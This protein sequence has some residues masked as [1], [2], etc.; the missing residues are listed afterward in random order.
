MKEPI[1]VWF[2]EDAPDE[3]KSLSTCGGDEDYLAYVPASY[4]GLH[5]GWLESGS[6]GA[7]GSIYKFQLP[8]GDSIVIGSHA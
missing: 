8:N 5:I 6:F 4:K 3:Y 7:C 1:Q 2:F